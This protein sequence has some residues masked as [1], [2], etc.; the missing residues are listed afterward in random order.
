MLLRNMDV[1][2]GIRDKL[3]IQCIYFY[4][5]N[6]KICCTTRVSK[7]WIVVWKGWVTWSWRAFSLDLVSFAAVTPA[8][9][10][11]CSSA[12][13]ETY[14]SKTTTNSS[15]ME[16]YIYTGNP[17]SQLFVNKMKV[18]VWRSNPSRDDI[19]RTCPDWL[20]SPPRLLHSGYQVSLRG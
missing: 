7:V 13:C 5:K 2:R 10:Y 17:W 4:V 16:I 12:L 9:C 20:W 3:L 18:T 11:C 14:C 19:F 1:L 15:E 6:R 8:S